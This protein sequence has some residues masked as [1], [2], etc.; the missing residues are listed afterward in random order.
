MSNHQQYPN[1]PPFEGGPQFQQAP[2]KKKHPVRTAILATVGGMV[3]LVVTVAAFGPSES[4]A[5]ASNP[6]PNVVS[7]TA[8]TGPSPDPVVTPTNK[9]SPKPTVAP[10]T[11]QPKPT[12]TAPKL[13]VGQEQAI[14]SAESYIDSGDFSRKGLIEQLKFEG[15]TT[16]EA[17]Y[18][19]DHITV[20]WTAEA[21]DSA[22]SYLESGSFSRKSLM[23]QL[24][25]EGFTKAQAAHGVKSVGL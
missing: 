22:A 10:K 21:D 5:P 19:V 15:F 20:N 2:A 23:D 13:S 17:T 14:E 6:L 3:A 9:P 4:Q 7:T 18:A 24:L 1:H 12:K 16:K 8:D 25:Y 11:T